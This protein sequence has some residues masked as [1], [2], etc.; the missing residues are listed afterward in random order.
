VLVAEENW[1]NKKEGADLAAPLDIDRRVS[2]FC[3]GYLR[4]LS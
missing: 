2:Q 1:K 4:Q 3:F